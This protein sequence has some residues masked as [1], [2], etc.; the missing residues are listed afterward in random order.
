[1]TMNVNWNSRPG[2]TI[3]D[4]LEYRGLSIDDFAAAIEL[5]LNKAEKLINGEVE[6][7]LQ[8]AEKLAD[9]F[10]SSSSFWMG[11]EVRYRGNPA[12]VVRN[13]LK[14]N[15][16]WLD[17][18]PVRDMIKFGW[19]KAS[20]SR[21]ERL[22]ACL[23]FFAVPSVPDWQE[24]YKNNLTAI[25]FR[26]SDTFENKIGPVSVWLR[27]GI[28]KAQEMSCK[29]WDRARLISK[30][31]ELRALTSEKDPGVFIDEIQRI[32]AS[33]GVAVIVARAPSG[34]R[35]SG[36]TYFVDD[37]RALILLSFRFKA[38]DQ[39]WFTFFHEI[40][41]L[42]LHDKQALFV[43]DGSSVTS[44]E[45]EEANKFARN[46]LIP[47]ELFNEMLSIKLDAKEITNARRVM[48]FSKKI[49]ICPGVVVG[50]LQFHKILP[51]NRL[52]KLKNRYEWQ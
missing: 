7:D 45:E 49:N 34:C 16:D 42:I 15:Q 50:Q 26:T 23:D 47:Q 6:I 41:H 28:I 2:D 9:F 52:N 43:E 17:S 51:Y 18:L 30:I 22:K 13:S 24:E 4:L 11:R 35:A 40:G 8:I 38:D 14:S 36:A 33:C 32:C 27:Y 46:V 39:F 3:V 10:G 19:I 48:K 12:R 37:A 25:A 44:D 20:R 29:P 5:S 1:M 21:D 31:P